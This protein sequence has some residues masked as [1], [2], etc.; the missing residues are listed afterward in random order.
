VLRLE[1]LWL[2][3]VAAGCDL[4]GFPLGRSA[5][6]SKIRRATSFFVHHVHVGQ[7]HLS[8]DFHT[9]ADKVDMTV[10]RRWACAPHAE[11]LSIL[12]FLLQSTKVQNVV[13]EGDYDACNNGTQC[14]P[15]PK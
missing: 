2:S 5:L 4:A 11:R 8:K 15:K 10:Q 1:H 14:A 13:R 7:M 9:P 6:D 3:E 12:C